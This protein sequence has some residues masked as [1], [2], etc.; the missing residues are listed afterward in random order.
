MAFWV[1]AA[2]L[3]LGASM[4]VA[5]PFLWANTRAAP[6]AAHDLAVY[7][8]QLKEIER[9][10]GHGLIGAEEAQEARAEIGRR[11]LRLAD[12]GAD[13]GATGGFDRL[14]R[15]AIIVA[16]VVVPVLAWSAYAVLGSPG[17]PDQQL[18]TRLSKNPAS[19]SLEELVARAEQHLRRNPED[20][21]G[22]DVLAPIYLRLG[23]NQDAVIAFG[24]A[25]RLSGASAE[26]EAGLGQAI[27]A[28][29]GGIVT[30][31]AQAAFERALAIDAK[32]PRA[33]FFLAIGY[34]QEGRVAE[35][36]ALWTQ[37]K[38]DLPPDSPWR[39]AADQQLARTASDSAA[40]EVASSARPAPK[41]EQ[42]DA[43][44]EMPSED[45]MAMIEGMVSRLDARLREN[46]DDPEG[47]QR[48][49]RSYHVLGKT[50][51]AKDALAR[52]TRALGDGSEDAR[53]LV[54]FAAQLGISR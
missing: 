42:A 14:A 9:D 21:R 2:L 43:A 3:T 15:A 47:W 30:A 17:L 20:G 10:A 34:A 6:D 33:R 8:D 32:D 25:I 51:E 38:G 12:A 4:A 39:G 5:W 35:A 52:G 37:M 13:S 22:W 27:M 40:G 44:K 36:R 11:I 54:A 1:I 16:A 50:A 26:R 18:A 31:D 41:P 19:S 53:R 48:L 23:R 29:A 45:R 46:P 49:V 28:A 7:R 24:N